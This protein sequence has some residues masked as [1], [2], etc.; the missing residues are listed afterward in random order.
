M[1]DLIEAGTQ[2]L[3]G[4]TVLEKCLRANDAILRTLE[5]EKVCPMYCCVLC[6]VY[7]RGHGLI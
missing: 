6:A 3:L 1:G 4:E 2:G 5:A 7:G